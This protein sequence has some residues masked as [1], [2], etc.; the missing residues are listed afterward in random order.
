MTLAGKL[1]LV[2]GACRG[3][4]LAI[5]Q[6]FVAEGARVVLTD[7]AEPDASLRAWAASQGE[8]AHLMRMDVRSEAEIQRTV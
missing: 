8:R 2:T 7:V 4:G 1:A 6:R 5:S 3:I